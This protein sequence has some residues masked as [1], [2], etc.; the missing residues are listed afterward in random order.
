MVGR[1]RISFASERLYF[2]CFLFAFSFMYIVLNVSTMKSV[3]CLQARNEA[4]LLKSS[5]HKMER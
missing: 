3:L 2:V 4:E 1:K 5:I